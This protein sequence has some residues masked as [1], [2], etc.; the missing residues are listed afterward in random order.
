MTDNPFSSLQTPAPT[1]S[2]QQATD[3][4]REHFG[5]EGEIKPLSS[6]RDQN[7][8]VSVPDGRKYVLKFANESESAGITDFQ[9]QALLHVARVAPEFPVPRLVPSSGGDLMVETAATGGSLHRMRLLT[10]LDGTPLQHA[11]G[12]TSIA[13]QTG[14]CLARLDLIL[15]DF[16]HPASEYALLWD[17]SNASELARLSQYVN[18]VDL[19]EL[20]DSRLSRFRSTVK[21]RLDAMR[22]QVIYNDMN[23][24]NLLVDSDNVNRLTGVIDFGDMVSSRLVNDVAVAAAYLCRIDDDPFAEVVEFLAAYT[25]ILPLSDD[26]ISLLPDLILTRHLTT[27]M[28]TH[29]RAS[30]YPENQEYIFRNEGRA[31]EMLL[32]V[33]N[34]SVENTADRFAAACRSGIALEAGA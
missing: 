28:I 26:E 21:P 6:E 20:C 34:L 30:L 3:L 23:P 32:Q 17:I 5:V 4:L 14:E 2:L 8:L 9:N 27:V 29:W 22:G 7:F 15:R 33:A 24:S 12:V 16:E 1:F 31:R 13:A 19:R 18:D 10:W 25:A 11:R